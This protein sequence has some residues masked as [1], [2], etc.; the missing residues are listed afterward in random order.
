MKVA[1]SNLQ[2]GSFDCEA[3]LASWNRQNYVIYLHDTIIPMKTRAGEKEAELMAD[4]EEIDETKLVVPVS[5]PGA[6]EGLVPADPLQYYISQT[7]QYPPLSKE[8]ERE[9]AIK[10]KETGD[11]DAAFRLITSNLMLVVKIAFEFRS[12]FQ[13]MLDLV[14]EGNYGLMRAVSKF[15]P[16]KGTRLST[17]AVYWI[18][19][20]MLKF[21]LDNWRL[22]KVGTTNVR[23]KLLYNLRDIEAKLKEGGLD[24]E[25][26]QLAEHF[27]AS[28][29]DVVDI[30][31][32]L[33][34]MDK[35][36]YQPVEEGSSR[37]VV[38]ILPSSDE[39]FS[40]YVS[41][42]QVMERF[43]DAVEKFKE[44]LKPSDRDLLD[45]RILSDEPLTL[46]EIGEEHGVTREA[47]RQAETR[48]MK[49]LK[50]FLSEELTD[51]GEV[52]SVED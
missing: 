21:L 22:V 48:L 43:R 30:Q 50:K 38:D 13:N 15:D 31:Q 25:P 18:R 52:G 40:E 8:E 32:S 14:Q 36:I 45:K 19:A 26:K 27:G 44:K 12:Q 29:Q 11:K 3:I 2:G 1:N 10:F 5:N 49:R 6:G 9:L 24:V 28:E 16:F 42:K 35:S 33:G 39:D 20:Y 47:V 7:K 51:V 37:L 17:Y 4:R 41:E 46:R 34:A 23:R